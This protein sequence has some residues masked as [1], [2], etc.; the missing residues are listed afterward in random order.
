[1]YCFVMGR[2]WDYDRRCV[3]DFVISEELSAIDDHHHGRWGHGILVIWRKLDRRL[4]LWAFP[5]VHSRQHVFPVVAA[6]QLDELVWRRGLIAD[7]ALSSDGCRA[8]KEIFLTQYDRSTVVICWF[9]W[10][11]LLRGMVCGVWL[12]WIGVWCVVV[13]DWFVVCGCYGLVCGILL[14]LNSWSNH[15]SSHNTSTSWST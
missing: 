13:M 1:M 12:L 2:K 4:V 5:R 7:N 11:C 3:S 9:S 14:L 10:V 15:I 8:I 6:N